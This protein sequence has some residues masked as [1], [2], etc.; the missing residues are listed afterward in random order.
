MPKGKILGIPWMSIVAPVYS[1]FL[2]FNLF[3]WFYDKANIYGVGY[4]NRT[5]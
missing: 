2:V 1:A 5:P 3:L 4:K